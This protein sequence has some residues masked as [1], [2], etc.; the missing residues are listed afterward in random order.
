MKKKNL[1]YLVRTYAM[2][3]AQTI[4]LQ[5]IRNLPRNRF[6][7]VTVPYAAR[8]RGDEDFVAAV[9]VQGDEVADERLVWSK[10]R[11]LSRAW[12]DIQRLI[13]RHDI[14][15]LHTHDNLS[16]VLVG[17]GRK[18]F[19]CPCVAS[20]YGWWEPRWNLK[21]RA[22][23]ELE[24]RFALPRFDAVYTVSE[25]M[26]RK[27]VRG[28]TPAQRIRV[29]HTGID[30]S[31]LRS[32]ESPKRAR[33]ALG[34]PDDAIVVGTVSRLSREK[35]H[36]HLLRAAARLRE[37]YPRLHLLILGNGPLRDELEALA[38]RLGIAERVHFTGFFADLP[39]ALSMMDVFALPSILDEGFP[40]AVIEAEAAGLPIV[41]SDIGGTRETL[42]PERTG[43]LVPPGDNDALSVA[44]S[45]LLE[46]D[47]LRARMSEEARR[48]ISA[49]L[50]QERMLARMGELYDETIARCGGAT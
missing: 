5:L 19:D 4:V 49:R 35:G 43:L 12:R 8:G 44:L 13:Q 27:V 21:I 28:G 41:A 1:L 23:Y 38:K 25:D 33:A 36:H 11:G 17:L 22:Y 2:G 20:A 37:R 26:K 34:I 39:L 30:L 46:D 15:L 18:H 32:G 45:R 29:I 50:T 6:R 3:G 47:A 10:T 31:S 24:R 48:F 40:T 9:R 42:L 16:N 7:I 14:D